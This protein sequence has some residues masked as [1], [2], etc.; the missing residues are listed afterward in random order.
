M[1]LLKTW[2]QATPVSPAPPTPFESLSMQRCSERVRGALAQL[3]DSEREV[4]EL[5]Y[6]KGLSQ[7]EIAADLNTPLGFA[8][9]S[10]VA[11][12]RKIEYRVLAK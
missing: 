11:A 1:R 4:L 10:T 2:H 6:Y 5:A 12:L 3:P 7:A 8:S 9:Y